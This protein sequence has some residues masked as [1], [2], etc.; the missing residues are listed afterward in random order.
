MVQRIT[1]RQ[2]PL[3]ARFRDLAK[4]TVGDRI[5][6]DGEHLLRDAVAAGVRIETAAFAADLF[7][8][9]PTLG[10]AVR[11]AGGTV[12]SVSNQVLDAISPVRQPSG[13]VAIAERPQY[14]V[15]DVLAGEPQ[16]LVLLARVQ[17]PGN[18]GAIVRA[19][20]G[21]GGTGVITVDGTADAFG[22]KALRGAMGSTLRL[23]VASD[24]SLS[25]AIDKVR[26]RG[27][28][29]LATAPR[30]GTPLPDA[31]LR[32][33]CAILLG[34]EGSGL[35][36]EAIRSADERLTI[37]MRAGIESMN[38]A[39]AAAIVLYEACRQRMGFGDVA[40]R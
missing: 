21:C 19:A 20:E 26:E 37:P 4:G 35:P 3:V 40:V 18:V 23:P 33:P 28:P 31:D 8:Q 39:A 5:L 15:D 29:V 13:V 14:A 17:D 7:D 32:A 36:A 9:M 1:S 34:G 12:V 27:I 10:D 6:L 25:T 30:G 11:R 2:N 24:T 22:W 38:V 16:L